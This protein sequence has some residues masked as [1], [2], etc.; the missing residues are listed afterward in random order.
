MLSNRIPR[1][2][3]SQQNIY[4]DSL[5]KYKPKHVSNTVCNTVFEFKP[6]HWDF[7]NRL[8]WA[9][10]KRLNYTHV[11]ILDRLIPMQR[12]E[13]TIY[14]SQGTL[15]KECKKSVRWIR[16]CIADLV[17]WGLLA[18]KSQGVKRTCL[19]RINNLF[20]VRDICKKIARSLPDFFACFQSYVS[21]EFLQERVK[22]VITRVLPNLITIQREIVDALENFI[23]KTKAGSQWFGDFFFQQRFER[24]DYEVPPPPPSA[25][26]LRD[27]KGRYALTKNNKPVI[28]PKIR[29]DKLIEMDETFDKKIYNETLN[30]QE[31]YK[32]RNS[33]QSDLMDAMAQCMKN[34]R[35]REMERCAISA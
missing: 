7:D 25:L 30:L 12:A 16:K 18:T 27:R 13:M 9:I 17:R 3:K 23:K 31:E 21:R 34:G 28:E 8:I 4:K 26:S 33:L 11:Y 29:Q 35:E 22:G 20:F 2:G 1:S 19:Y 14:I 24:T 15:A 5:S 32:K 6:L 10:E